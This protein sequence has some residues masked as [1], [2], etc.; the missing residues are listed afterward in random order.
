MQADKFSRYEI[1]EELGQ[2]GMATVYRAYDPLFER[3]VALKILKQELL[4]NS[5]IRER[6]ERETKIIAKLEHAA[7]V[8]V[9]DVG[10]DKDQLFFVMRYMSG[11]SLSDRI[12]NKSMTFSEIAYIIQRVAAA[13]DYAHSKDVIHRDL[14]PGNILFD[15]YNNPFISDFGIAKI[16]RA[17]IKLTH[18][19]IIGTPTYMSPEQAQGEEVDGRSDIYSLGVILFEMLSGKTPYEATT[20]L[21]MA[22]KHAAEPVPHILRVNPDLPTG[23]ETVIEKVMAKDR[24]QRYSSA[25]EFA[26][27]FSAT[28]AGNAHLVAPIPKPVQINDAVLTPPPSTGAH[29]R[30]PI[31]RFWMFGGFIILTLAALWGYPRFAASFNPTS[32]TATSTFTASPPTSTPTEFIVPTSTA[33][34][35]NEVTPTVNPILTI[36]GADKIALSANNDIFMMDMDGRNILQLTNTNVPKFDLQWLPDGNE[37]LYGEGNCFYTINV[38]VPE[39]ASEKLACFNEEDFDGFR[40]SPDGTHVAISIGNRLIVLRFDKQTLST[41]ATTFELQG[42]E[43]L[44]LDYSD[45]SVKGA[46]WSATG[47]ELAITYE[48]VVGQRLGDTIRVLDIDTRRCQAADPLIMDEFPAKHFMPEGYERYPLLPS[49]HWDGNQ[50]FLFNSFKRN[51]AY[52]ELYLYDMSTMTERKVNPID[53][54]CCYNSAIFSPDGTH[55]LFV[56]QDVRR[57]ENS[58]TQLYYVPIDQMDSGITFTPVRLPLQFFLDLREDIELALRPVA[59]Q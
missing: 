41:V 13:L 44:C 37:L 24:D 14:K 26:N 50:R 11:G 20:P 30:Q 39:V 46:L 9:Y 4:A 55:I 5:Q 52:G 1:R 47:Q 38:E 58:I 7:I 22:F 49:Y 10:R 59:P 42:L 31:S 51:T 15:E 45:V 19:G 29:K 3:E 2:G 40:V 27:D 48:S 35:V 23:I 57:G 25:V 12:Q 16:S 21:G 53:G 43:D 17:S 32:E 36:G 8:P 6:F 33:T 56:F 54:V 34:A 28:I 18:S